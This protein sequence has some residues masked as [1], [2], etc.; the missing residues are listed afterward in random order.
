M[1]AVQSSFRQPCCCTS[2]SQQQQQQQ[3]QNSASQAHVGCFWSKKL[4]LL[5]VLLLLPT[6]RS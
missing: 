6:C 1:Q 2:T 3:D 5:Q 4:A